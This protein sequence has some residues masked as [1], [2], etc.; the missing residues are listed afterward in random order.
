MLIIFVAHSDIHPEFQS[1]ISF[2]QRRRHI[3]PTLGIDIR[4]VTVILKDSLRI[5]RRTSMSQLV[6][7]P[8]N[9]SSL[10][11]RSYTS[12]VPQKQHRALLNISHLDAS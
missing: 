9:W 7:K 10:L 11:Y 4:R 1:E 5:L 2:S 12:C 3:I 8:L 6:S